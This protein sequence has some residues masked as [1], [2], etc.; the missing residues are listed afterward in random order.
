MNLLIVDDEALAR[1][2]LERMLRTLGH[3]QI[4]SCSSGA[5]ALEAAKENAFDIAFLDINMP[6]MNGLDLGYELRYLQPQLG[7]VFQ[8]AYSEHALEAFDIG[9]V[10][11]LVKPY[12]LDQLSKVLERLGEERERARSDVRLMSKNGENY[13][14]LRPEEIYYIKADLSEVMVRTK[15]GFSYMSKK[16]SDLERL[17][18]PY[19]FVQVHRSYLINIDTIKAMETIEQSKIRFSFEG[20]NDTVES[21]KDGAKAFRNR[22]A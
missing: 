1:S 16:I 6:Q 18:T 8:T 14:L 12:S 9:A 4:E 7:I 13:F 17:L 11:Y 10:G 20:I 15:K 19:H 3:E 5:D 21:S 2:R 22:F